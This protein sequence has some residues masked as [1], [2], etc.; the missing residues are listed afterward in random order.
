MVGRGVYRYDSP[1]TW[2][3]LAAPPPVHACCVL[4]SRA[5]FFGMAA[6]DISGMATRRTLASAWLNRHL[7]SAARA[8]GAAPFNN[9]GAY[10][11][12]VAIS[13]VRAMALR[14]ANGCFVKLPPV[15][16]PAV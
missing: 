16:S 14:L 6:G 8:G 11:R 1:T 12:A 3:R 7:R 4:L 15:L 5:H 10:K 9:A 2:H 13:V